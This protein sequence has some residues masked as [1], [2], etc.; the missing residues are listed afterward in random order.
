MTAAISHYEV[1]VFIGPC[2]EDEA[3]EIAELVADAVDGRL[4]AVVGWRKL[5]PEEQ[6]LEEED[7]RDASE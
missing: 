7:R 3:D 5:S 6:L 4:G 2:V 1:T